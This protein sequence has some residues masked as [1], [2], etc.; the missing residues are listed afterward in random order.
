MTLET[1][2]AAYVEHRERLFRVAYRML[3]TVADAEDVV[4]E[5]W[6]RW[7]NADRTSVRDPLGFLIRT[8]T[9]LSIDRLRRDRARR[10]T[11][12]GEWLA[13]P[14]PTKT[15][16]DEVAAR[17]EVALAM[18]R[19][20]ET[21]SPLERAVFVLREAFD[22]PHAEIA[23]ILDRS[24]EAVR[25]LAARARRHV[26][27]RRPRF[28]TDSRVREQVTRRFVAA[29]ETGDLGGLM[30]VLAPG[31][32]L[33]ADG[34]GRVRAP[35]L[36]L[37]GAD[38]VARFLLAVAARELGTV[39]VTLESVNG[40]QS[41]V[42]RAA[43]RPAA[44]LELAVASGRVEAVYLVGNPDKLAAMSRADGGAASSE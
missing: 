16:E 10:E 5:A 19:V 9:R 38:R 30:E 27:E 44:V 29:I 17:E 4:Q 14:I 12:T 11:Y 22:L 25:Q 21:L 40:L 24:P 26:E 41:I 13:E 43:G 36:P 7:A 28:E 35:L 42:V 32:T 33:V 3:G 1:R 6:I 18:L 8:T 37:V 2:D 31:V 15:P 39:E 23:D 20:L 34:G